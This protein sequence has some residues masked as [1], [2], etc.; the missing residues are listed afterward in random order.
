MSKKWLWPDTLS[1]IRLDRGN[2]IIQLRMVGQPRGG[3]DC[4]MLFFVL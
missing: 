1:A 3:V 2:G 4:N